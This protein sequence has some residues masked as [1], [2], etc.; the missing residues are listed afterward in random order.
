MLIPTGHENMKGRRWPVITIALIA[1]NFAAFLGTHWR[2]DDQEPRL[3]EIR[4]H[5]LLL[6][7]MH[8]ELHMT[9]D[10]QDLVTTVSRKYPV[11]WKQ[12][13]SPDRKVADSWDAKIRLTEDPRDLQQEMDS[14]GQQY[15]DIQQDSILQ[16]YAYVPAHPAPISY[17]TANFLHG[18]WLHIIGNMWFLWLAGVVLEDT[19]GRVIYPVFYFL[20]GI[21]ALMFHGWTNPGSLGPTLGASGAVAALMGA[22]LVRFPQTK[23]QMRWIFGFGLR[24]Y[25]FKAKAYWLLPLWLLMEIFSGSISGASS[26]VAHWA[27]VGGFVFGAVGAVGLRYCGLEHVA[28]QVIESKVTWTADPAVVQATEKMEQG[29]LDEA[30]A[31]LQTHVAAKPDSLEAYTILPQLY[32]RKNDIPNY[33]QAIIKLCQ[34][35]LKEKDADAAWE[36]FGEY[37]NS[38]GERMPASTWLELCRAAEGQQRIERAVVEYDKLAKTYPSEKQSLLALMAAGRLSLKLNQPAEALR[39]FRAAAGSPVPHLD[40]ETNI[41]GGIREAE[42]A[43]TTTAVPAAKG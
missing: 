38:G 3:G 24:S 26:G 31:L 7:A 33:Q 16:R 25:K 30:I 23:I 21:I 40:W 27:H 5:I 20:S 37:L 39:F 35:H 15:F 11:E 14:L 1:I 4:A 29:N 43:L 22:F 9:P 36:D 6:A 8:P 13:A 19:W 17:L 34:L 18:G 10:E 12:L 41:Q 32:W 42:K 2:I 28:N